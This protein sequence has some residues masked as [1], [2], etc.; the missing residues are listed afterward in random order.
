MLININIAILVVMVQ[1]V[2]F[3]MATGSNSRYVNW[4][5]IIYTNNILKIPIGR[6]KG[7]VKT[8]FFS[9][10]GMKGTFVVPSGVQE[11]I[12]LPMIPQRLHFSLS[13]SINGTIVVYIDL[14]CI[15]AHPPTKYIRYI[16]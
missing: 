1:W 3:F 11:T 10:H 8:K 4:T 12:D 2:E 9:F 6:L 15:P 14:F 5:S 13:F 16:N 7:R